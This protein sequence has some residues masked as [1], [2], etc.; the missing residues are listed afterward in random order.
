MKF[1]SKLIFLSVLAMT[2][3]LGS[4]KKKCT[5]NKEDTHSGQIIYEKNDGLVVVMPVS[6]YM[7]SNVTPQQHL[8]QSNHT[9]ADR[10]EVSFDGGANK[11]P[12]D[13]NLYNIV[14]FPLYVTCEA[15][16]DREVLIDNTTQTVTYNINITECGNCTEQYIMENYVL[17]PK[18]PLGYT[19]IQNV[20][21]TEVKE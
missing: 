14:A 3:S 4:C 16:L 21:R 9:Y 2:V 20:T 15:A 7:T 18:V 1:Y 13:Y 17:I 6:G 10:Y 8:I 5:I 11:G 12:V 19:L